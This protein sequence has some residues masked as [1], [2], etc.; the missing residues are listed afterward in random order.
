M[1]SI[2]NQTQ[3]KEISILSKVMQL[4]KILF[5]GLIIS[6]LGSLPLGPLNL[7]T[8]YISVAKGT[9]AGLIFSI[10]CIV[11]E[12]IFVRLALVFMSWI[13]KRQKLFKILECLTIAII[14]ALAIFSFN[15]AIQKTG[16]TSAMPAKINHP[17]WS[18]LLLSALDPMKIPFWF[19]WSTFL[20]T[21]NILLAKNQ[22]Y[23]FYVV[24]IG[25]GSLLGFLIFIYGGNYFIGTIKAH[26]DIINWIIGSILSVTAI[27]QIYRLKRPAKSTSVSKKEEGAK[28]TQLVNSANNITS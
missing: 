8:T 7:F 11:S 13:S 23:N 18:G 1:E 2:E 22:Y 20:I 4:S 6:F 21:N 14:L 5:W 19:L 3:G 26:Q 24:G 28:V 27:I 12:L 15:A 25:L 17:F 10:G 9:H 16:F